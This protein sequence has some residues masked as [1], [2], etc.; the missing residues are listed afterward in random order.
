MIRH[1]TES[2]S[3]NFCKIFINKECQNEILWF[4][5]EVTAKHYTDLRQLLLTCLDQ[6]FKSFH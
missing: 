6:Q 3:S 1:C 5:T 2:Y 4:H